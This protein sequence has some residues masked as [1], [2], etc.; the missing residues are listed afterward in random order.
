MQ[1]QQV[2]LMQETLAPTE[3]PVF[4]LREVF[5]VEYVEYV[6]VLLLT[7]PAPGGLGV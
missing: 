5:D 4:V 3:R 2:F 1:N 7:S 6:E